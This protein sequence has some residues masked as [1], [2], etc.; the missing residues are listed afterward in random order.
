MFERV[1]D[2]G[3]NELLICKGRSLL[4]GGKENRYIEKVRHLGGTLETRGLGP[5]LRMPS[6]II[7]SALELVRSRGDLRA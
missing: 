2:G 1:A 3:I 7:P 6:Q 5:D 4:G